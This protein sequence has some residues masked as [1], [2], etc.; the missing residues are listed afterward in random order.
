MRDRAFAVRKQTA[1]LQNH[2]FYRAGKEEFSTAQKAFL[3][4]RNNTPHTPASATSSR[5]WRSAA[6]FHGQ[7]LLKGRSSFGSIPPHAMARMA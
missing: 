3:A 1:R 5:S 6:T 4:P 2:S 7:S